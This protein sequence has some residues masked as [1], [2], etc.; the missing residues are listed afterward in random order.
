MFY[1][2]RF[3]IHKC[4]KICICCFLYEETRPVKHPFIRYSYVLS[5]FGAVKGDVFC[6]FHIVEYHHNVIMSYV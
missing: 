2:T 4:C 3:K 6:M 1:F 5:F